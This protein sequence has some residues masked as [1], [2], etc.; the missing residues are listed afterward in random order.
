MRRRT[1]PDDPA[2]SRVFVDSSAWFAV[3][4]SSD[5]KHAEADA[6]LRRAV[7]RG[8][9]LF[10]THLVVAEV[11]RLA[12][13]RMGI[14]PAMAFLDRLEAS[15]LVSMIHVTAEHHRIARSWLQRL[16]DQPISYTDGV[17]FAVMDAMRCRTAMTFDRHFEIAGFRLWRS[18]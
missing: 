17:S 8:I 6:M 12:L 16:A 5:G 18:S 14:R 3:A 10:T 2:P 7:T 13:G 11:H 9:A 15:R 4:S 1:A